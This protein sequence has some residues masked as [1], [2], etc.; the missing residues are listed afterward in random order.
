[1][2]IVKATHGCQTPFLE[3]THIRTLKDTGHT[4]T[5]IDKI[6]ARA[7]W[8]LVQTGQ[9]VLVV[10]DYRVD[11]QHVVCTHVIEQAQ[12]MTASPGQNHAMAN[13]SRSQLTCDF[14]PRAVHV[15]RVRA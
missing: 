10:R 3:Y 15:L 13:R 11:V 14:S 12:F 2:Q 9:Q 1:M 5:R 8:H 4:Q 7:T 6:T